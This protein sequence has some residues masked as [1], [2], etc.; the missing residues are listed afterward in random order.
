MMASG[1][2]GCEVCL[3]PS[4]R[5]ELS[6]CRQKCWSLGTGQTEGAWGL[7]LRKCGASEV[8]PILL[9]CMKRKK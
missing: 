4:T 2:L 3:P 6:V 8:G 5:P 9:M 7:L 1:V